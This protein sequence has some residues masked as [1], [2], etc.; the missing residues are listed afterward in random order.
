M[1]AAGLK[2]APRLEI[3]GANASGATKMVIT[4]GEMDGSGQKDQATEALQTRVQD[5]VRQLLG[6]A[7]RSDFSSATDVEVLQDFLSRDAPASR[8]VRRIGEHNG[9][10]F[11]GAT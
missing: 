9:V 8:M 2:H 7:R 3:S 5:F 11:V 10:Q 1:Q 4:E 6:Y